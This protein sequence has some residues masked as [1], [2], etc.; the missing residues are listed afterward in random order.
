MEAEP[1]PPRIDAICRDED[2][3]DDFCYHP[4]PA[5]SA[6]RRQSKCAAGLLLLETKNVIG[7]VRLKHA[8]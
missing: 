5:V 1:V 4:I 6:D 2:A 7:R 3:G 8:V